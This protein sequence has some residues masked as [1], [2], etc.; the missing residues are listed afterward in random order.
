MSVVKIHLHPE[1]GC[2]WQS[3]YA[4][5]KRMIGLFNGWTTLGKPYL[6]HHINKYIQVFQPGLVLKLSCLSL[7]LSHTPLLRF[8]LVHTHTLGDTRGRVDAALSA[9]HWGVLLLT[10]VWIE[11]S[12]HPLLFGFGCGRAPGL[13]FVLHSIMAR[14]NYSLSGEGTQAVSALPLHP[15]SPCRVT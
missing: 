14:H 3:Y 13:A 1:A 15:T 4:H 8:H 11:A 5:V 10:V 9:V 7:S 12:V 2:R 6:Q